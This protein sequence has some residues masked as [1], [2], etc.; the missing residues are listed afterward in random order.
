MSD[1]TV[2]G[3]RD[4]KNNRES[5]LSP[6]LAEVAIVYDV[7]A[8]NPRV[9]LFFLA[10]AKAGDETFAFDARGSCWRANAH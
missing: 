7:R 9:Y 8:A 4:G 6:E 10:R 3:P 5:A 1:P 2:L